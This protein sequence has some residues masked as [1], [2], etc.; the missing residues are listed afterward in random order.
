MRSDAS[1]KRSL[2]FKQSRAALWTIRHAVATVSD[3][4]RQLK[5]LR[6]H[7]HRGHGAA[8]ATLRAARHH[9]L[10]ERDRARVEDCVGKFAQIADWPATRRSLSRHAHLARPLGDADS[11]VMAA[12]AGSA[13]TVAARMLDTCDHLDTCYGELVVTAVSAAR[14]ALPKVTDPT[15]RRK[16]A[17]LMLVLDQLCTN[18]DIAWAFTTGAHYWTAPERTLH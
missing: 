7:L 12:L 1:H 5:M 4:L 10:N 2:E 13:L 17:E 11:R 6:R 18:Q 14:S 8:L 3:S 9:S 15:H 16:A